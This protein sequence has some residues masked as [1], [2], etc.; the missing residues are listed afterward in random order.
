MVLLPA[1]AVGKAFARVLRDLGEAGVE[2][3]LVVTEPPPDA[4]AA[5]D[6]LDMPILRLATPGSLVDTE[7]AIISL[8][9]D[10]E[11]QVRRRVEQIYERL[12]A[13]LVDD[14]GIAA[15]AAEVADCHPPADHRPRRVLPG[16]G[17]RARRRAPPMTSGSAVGV[18]L[19]ARDPRAL[20]ARP[21]APFG[22]PRRRRARG[23]GRAAPIAGHAGRLPGARRRRGDDR[24]RPT[25]RRAGRASPRHR[26]GQAARRDRGSASSPG[27]LPGR[28]AL[29]VARGR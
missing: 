23:A 16:P 1:S 22:W 15:L 3:V 29:W 10:R 27:R 19:A 21:T 14:T 2:A 24:P 12:L 20:G 4:L 6:E 5:A 9:V 11:S 7:R 26:A 17:H 8:I 18:T 13:T 25:G 28:P